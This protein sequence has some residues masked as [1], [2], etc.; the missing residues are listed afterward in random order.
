MRP[1]QTTAL[2]VLL[3]AMPA[4][5][6]ELPSRKSGLW[7][8]KMSIEGVNAPAQVLQQ[9]IDAATDQMMMSLSGP[10]SASVCKR[11]VKTDANAI[12]IDSACTI[13][14]N[15]A[16]VHTAI[17][18]SLDSAY[19]MTVTS[20][21]DAVPGGKMT[22]TIDAKRLGPCTAEQKPG[23]I[24]TANGRTINILEAM[25]HVPSQGVP[26]SSPQSPPQ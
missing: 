26:L 8:V 24:I 15:T 21:G 12:A 5:A 10:F 14:R 20:Q 23:D 1:L 25:K 18:G 9:C 4:F 19:T 6:A 16:T 11:D 3:G 17:T 22:M 2:L 13:G 7:E